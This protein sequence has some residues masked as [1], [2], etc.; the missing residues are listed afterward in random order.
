[1]FG[2]LASYLTNDHDV[3]ILIKQIINIFLGFRYL[4]YL[5]SRF[6]LCATVDKCVPL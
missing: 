6:E 3:N 2:L 5:L 4:L 1:M